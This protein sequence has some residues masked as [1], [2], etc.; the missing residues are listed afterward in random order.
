MLAIPFVVMAIGAAPTAPVK[1]IEGVICIINTAVNWLFFLLIALVVI[2]II[3]AAFKYLTA[4]GD[5]EK[6][7]SAN[8]TLIY[9]VVAIVVAIIAK[10]LP[11]LVGTLFGIAFTAAGCG[12]GT[13]TG[14]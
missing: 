13:S 12:G 10:A 11:Y 8:H 3:L 4:A 6:V 14:G 2:F 7:K 1:T 9:A 5:P